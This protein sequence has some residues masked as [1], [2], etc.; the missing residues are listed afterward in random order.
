[1]T[2]R[3]GRLVEEGF[4]LKVAHDLD[5]TVIYTD[6]TP[7]PAR[8]E[9]QHTPYLHPDIGDRVR[10]ITTIITGRP[11]CEL[12]QTLKVLSHFG[13]DGVNLMCN[14][15]VLFEQDHIATVKADQLISCGATH[16]VEDNPEYRRVM[17]EYWDGDCISVKEW[18]RMCDT[19]SM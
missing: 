15:L 17:G 4:L 3:P 10:R 2:Y 19:P 1:M 12:E 14:P 7:R 6:V 8:I 11:A 9:I 16:Y 5:Y 13:L 18:V